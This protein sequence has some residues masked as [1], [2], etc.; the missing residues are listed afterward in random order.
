LLNEDERLNL[1][2]DLAECG[3]LVESGT[4]EELEPVLLRLEASAQRIGEIIYAQVDDAEG[5]DYDD[6][7]P[8]DEPPETSAEV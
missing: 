4:V 3:R 7:P 8:E 5:G 2:E 1:E 6:L